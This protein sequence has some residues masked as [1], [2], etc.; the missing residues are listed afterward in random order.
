VTDA[1]ELRTERLLLRP[2]APGDLAAFESFANDPAYRRY[3][4]PGHPTPRAFV[5]RNVA[6]DRVTE[7]SWVIVRDDEIAG[8]IFLGIDVQDRVGE[9]ACLLAH[10]A[11]GD[12]IAGE[13]GRA[14]VAY[15][16]EHLAV[17]K[18]IARADASNVASRRAMEKSGMKQEGLLRAHRAA[19]NGARRDEV[20]Y[21]LLRSEWAEQS[22]QVRPNP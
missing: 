19:G 11:W 18:I 1:R 4:G 10:A 8:S 20:V 14:V 7:P 3:L 5:E 9:V 16:F 13:A 21:G 6:A 17:E 22:Q 2:F 12:G 15:A